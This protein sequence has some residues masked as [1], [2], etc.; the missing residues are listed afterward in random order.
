MAAATYIAIDLGASSGRHLA[1]SFDGRRLQLAEIYR[2]ENG[3]V[4]AGGRLHWD[5]LQLWQHVQNGLRAR[6]CQAWQ[7]QFAAWESIRGVS[8]SALLGR[9]DELLGNPVCYRDPRTDGMMDRAFQIVP[10]E[11]IFAKTGLQFMQFNTLFQLLAM[12]LQKSPLLDVAESLLLMPDVFH[13]LLTGVKS[14]EMTDAS[15]TQ[16]FNP[17]EGKW[18]TDLLNRFGLPTRI[19]GTIVQPG[20]KLGPLL[21]QVAAA[22]EFEQ[23]GS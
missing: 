1:G 22:T 12:K 11:E 2:F 13:W 19:L 8:I 10:R 20:T 5:L 7:R 4:A 16:F 21:P 6:R 14:N 18:A 3:P 17:A 23:R 15:T 9:G